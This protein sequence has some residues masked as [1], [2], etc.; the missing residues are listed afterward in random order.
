MKFVLTLLVCLSAHAIVQAVPAV[1]KNIPTSGVRSRPESKIVTRGGE[2]PDPEIQR[3][4]EFVKQVC[5]MG[6]VAKSLRQ[7]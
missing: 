3:R 7:H 4:R 5:M 1:S 2:D 6:F